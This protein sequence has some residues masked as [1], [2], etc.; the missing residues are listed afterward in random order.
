MIGNSESFKNQKLIITILNIAFR[1]SSIINSLLIILKNKQKKK[2]NFNQQL[3][4][5]IVI[6]PKIGNF[7]DNFFQISYQILKKKSKIE[8][9]LIK[10]FPKI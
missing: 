10:F 6:W 7:T 1:M 3:L 5:F 9:L 8:L 2:L 4:K